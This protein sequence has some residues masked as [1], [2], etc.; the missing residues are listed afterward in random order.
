MN[1]P[2][3][4]VHSSLG[5]LQRYKI[6][7]TAPEAAFDDIAKRAAK[8]FGAAFAGISFF[9]PLLAHGKYIVCLLNRPPMVEGR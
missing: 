2:D 9:E 5:A 7:H 8:I 3:T 1:V 4:N 6:L